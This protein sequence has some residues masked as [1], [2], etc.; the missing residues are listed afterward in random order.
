M[1][2]KNT[3]IENLFKASSQFIEFIFQM[4]FLMLI[5]NKTKINNYIKFQIKLAKMK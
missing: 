2:I 4:K 3:S 1:A 5:K